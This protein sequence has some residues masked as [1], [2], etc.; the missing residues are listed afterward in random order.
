[1]VRVPNLP[2]KRA[3][4]LFASEEG[5]DAMPQWRKLR[6]LWH[7]HSMRLSIPL[8]LRGVLYYGSILVSLT[9][10]LVL[11]PLIAVY[12]CFLCWKISRE[13]RKSGKDVLTVFGDSPSCERRMEQVL[14][15]LNSR[16]E[17]LNW[18]KRATWDRWSIGP[19]VFRFYSFL[20]PQPFRL[21]SCL[22]IVFVFKGFFWP[23]TFSFGGLQ[24]T[25]AQ[26]INRLERALEASNKPR[27]TDVRA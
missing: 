13:R 24:T 10:C 9:L 15:L 6:P 20:G 22:P 14:P 23:T 17:F 19:Q 1:M 3:F 16:S 7:H 5:W 18:S 2:R 11:S 26:V 12:W 4:G 27:Q 8:R 21:K 25:E